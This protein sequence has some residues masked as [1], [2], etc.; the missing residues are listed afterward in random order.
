MNCTVF[1]ESWQMECCGTAFSIGDKVKWLVYQTEPGQILTPVDLGMIEYCYE[2]HDTNWENLLVL[3]GKGKT[4][5]ILY[6]TFAP[7]ADNP[8]RLIS[9]GG[10]LFD[11]KRAEGFEKKIDPMEPTGY[12]VELNECFIRHS[13]QE[14]VTF[15]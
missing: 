12:V 11:S 2:A 7:S 9:V 6:E 3:E 8:R 13:K 15:K 1:Y 14:E 4:I 5:K 10:K